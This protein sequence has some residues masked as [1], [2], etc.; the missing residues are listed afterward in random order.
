MAERIN[1]I[2][3]VSPVERVQRVSRAGGTAAGQFGALLQKE[4]KVAAEPA[5]SFSK[6]A[7][8]RAAERGIQ[9]DDALMGQLADSVERAQAKGATNILAFDATRA[10]IINVPH[11]RVITTMSQEEMEENIFTNIDGAVLLK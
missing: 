7:Q 2:Q 10:F 1:S 8:N 4:I 9:V 5:I 3:G 11:G 6:H